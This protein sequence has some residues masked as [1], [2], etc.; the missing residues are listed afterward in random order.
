MPSVYPPIY[1]TAVGQVRLLIPDVVH[2]E[3]NLYLFEDEQIDALL[4]LYAENVKRA[5]AQAKDIIATDQALLLKVVRTD[6][7]TVDGARLATELR[8]QAKALRDQA[9]D[10]A[11]AE[12]YDFFKIVYPDVYTYPPEATPRPFEI[13]TTF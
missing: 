11:S 4:D 3:D 1:S 9:D 12:A 7:L 6:D 10:E 2:D 5:A 13:L 8:L